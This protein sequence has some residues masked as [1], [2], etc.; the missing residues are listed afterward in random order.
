MTGRRT[1][2]RIF[3]I[4]AILTLVVAV[5]GFIMTIVLNAFVLDKYNAYG[6]VPIP[7]TSTLHL[8]AGEATVSFHVQTVGSSSGGGLPVPPLG[9]TIVPPQGVA[10]PPV[11]E[12]YAPPP[13]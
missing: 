2:P 4:A 3:V 12:N 5:V 10:D 13:R 7:G 6:E 8:P 1:P 11:T 9:L